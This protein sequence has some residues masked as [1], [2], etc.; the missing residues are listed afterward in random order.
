MSKSALHA[1]ELGY[2]QA[3]DAVVMHPHEL[4]HVALDTARALADAGYRPPLRPRDIPVAGR[5]GAATGRN[6]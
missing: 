1:R 3:A 4:L 6:R 5:T 2:L